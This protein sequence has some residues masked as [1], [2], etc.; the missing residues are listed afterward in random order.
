MLAD[1]LLIARIFPRSCGARSQNI[2]AYYMLN[3]LIR[4]IYYTLTLSKYIRKVEDNG[5]K[6]PV[7]SR[8]IIALSYTRES[9]YLNKLK[10]YNETQQNKNIS[11]SYYCFI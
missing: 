5:L 4:C 9:A 11:L 8:I 10:I 7:V 3:H 2:R 1:I 6:W